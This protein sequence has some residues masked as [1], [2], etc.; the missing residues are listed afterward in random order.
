MKKTLMMCH[1]LTMQEIAVSKQGRQAMPLST[2]MTHTYWTAPH[3]ILLIGR[4][5]F[6]WNRLFYTAHFIKKRN[7][8]NAML[9]PI[10]LIVCAG[11]FIRNIE[12]YFNR[13]I[14]LFHMKQWV[15]SSL[16]SILFHMKQTIEF[17]PGLFLLSIKKTGEAHLLLRSPDGYYQSLDMNEKESDWFHYLSPKVLYITNELLSADFLIFWENLFLARSNMFSTVS[18]ETLF[19]F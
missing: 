3:L 7:V 9:K 15:L 17:C 5:S 11:C 6:T 13:W 16:E 18:H 8:S 4:S 10:V 14:K 1:L 19:Y 2:A 12:P